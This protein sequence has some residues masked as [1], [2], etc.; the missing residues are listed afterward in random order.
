[1]SWISLTETLF[2]QAI[3]FDSCLENYLYLMS[4]VIFLSFF[5]IMI[6][7]HLR[8]PVGMSCIFLCVCPT[9]CDGLTFV[10]SFGF[11]TGSHPI[12]VHC[13]LSEDHHH[14]SSLNFPSFKQHKTLEFRVVADIWDVLLLISYFL[15]RNVY[16]LYKN[17]KIVTMWNVSGLVIISEDSS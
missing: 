12:I 14:G 15:S 13:N 11:V 9:I 1:M 6:G 7:Y 2:W 10:K 17:Y 16:F 8:N 5:K 4:L 3:L